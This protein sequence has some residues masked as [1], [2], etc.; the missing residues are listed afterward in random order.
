MGSGESVRTSASRIGIVS[1]NPIVTEPTIDTE[2]KRLSRVFI[3][4]G[5]N[6][7]I[8]GNVADAIVVIVGKVLWLDRK[9]TV[10]SLP[11]QLAITGVIFLA[12]A[13]IDTE[14]SERRTCTKGCRL[15]FTGMPGKYI[16]SIPG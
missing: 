16:D 6:I 5:T 7:R 1:R 15:V 9:F 4:D 14:R 3:S 11:R 8:V 2:V 12:Y 10:S 13:P